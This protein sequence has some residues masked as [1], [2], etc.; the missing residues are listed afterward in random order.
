MS[1]G[2]P[3]DELEAVEEACTEAVQPELMRLRTEC[4]DNWTVPNK[5]HTSLHL[6]TF[7]LLL[8]HK[9]NDQSNCV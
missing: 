6:S 5:G 1:G 8:V 2:E 3:R 9:I 7:D 4:P